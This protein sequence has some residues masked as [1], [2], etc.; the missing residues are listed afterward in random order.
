MSTTIVTSEGD[1]EGDGKVITLGGDYACAMT[2]EKHK[3]T[4]QIYR[5][6]NRDKH[7]FEM[8]DPARGAN[9]KVMEITYIRK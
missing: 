3:P 9:S 2:G 8:H 7:M 6:L 5:I 4:T 1:A